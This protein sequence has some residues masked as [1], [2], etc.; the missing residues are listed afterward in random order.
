MTWQLAQINVARLHAPLDDP[1]TQGFVDG[2]Q[3]VNALADDAP[4]F[5]WR[6]QTESGDATE[7]QAFDD[8]LIIVNMSVW[9]S[10]EALGDFVYRSGHVEFLRRKRE[11]FE[12]YG[13]V[14]V[15]LWWVPAASLP[16]VGEGVA[17]LATLEANGPTADVFTFRRPAPAPGAPPA[18]RPGR[19]GRR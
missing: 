12:R 7:I 9:D 6:L 3:R 4:G 1:R 16:T 17:R 8:E 2:L 18:V 13:S 10:V 15:A 14:Q 11:W 19:G 5:V